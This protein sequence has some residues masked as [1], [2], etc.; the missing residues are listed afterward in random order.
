MIVAIST[1]P[2]S[3]HATYV[4]T[5]CESQEPRTGPT[6]TTV[7]AFPSMSVMVD[8]DEDAGTIS[9]VGFSGVALSRTSCSVSA[10]M[11]IDNTSTFTQVFK[12]S[13]A[14]ARTHTKHRKQT[15]APL[16]NKE[17]SRF[18]ARYRRSSFTVRRQ[19]N[20]ACLFPRTVA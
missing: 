15:I 16:P 10:D 11:S 5:V 8:I 3:V 14:F 4:S 17:P 7:T 2:F 12:Y 6:A 20:E 18:I 9:I 1:I 19:A 13:C